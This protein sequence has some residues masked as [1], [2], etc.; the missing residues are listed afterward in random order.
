M[1]GRIFLQ[2][3]TRKMKN[4]EDLPSVKYLYDTILWS[5]IQMRPNETCYVES[6][7]RSYTSNSFG[8]RG[9]DFIDNVDALIV[10]CSVTYGIGLEL[11]DTWGHLVSKELGYSYNLLAYP[12]GSIAK[13]VR[14]IFTYLSTVGRPK[15]ILALFPEPRRVDLYEPMPDQ[16]GSVLI[17]ANDLRLK[18]NKL[19]DFSYASP[20]NSFNFYDIDYTTLESVNAIYALDSVCSL[21]GIE[22]L[23]TTW[24]SRKTIKTYSDFSSFFKLSIESGDDLDSESTCHSSDSDTYK[25]ASDNDHWGSHYHMH[26]AEEFVRRLSEN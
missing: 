26:V 20:P 8:H 14:Q 22:L 7:K 21:I 19:E 12:G 3:H 9:P 4:K 23:W 6:D 17:N 2:R 11:E 1:T 10:G 24:D 5:Y 25:I 13:M 15:R 18:L 16:H